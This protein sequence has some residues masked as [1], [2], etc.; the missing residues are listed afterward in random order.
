MN[1]NR[2]KLIKT[3]CVMICLTFAIFTNCS[4]NK[5]NEK[6]QLDHSNSQSQKDKPKWKNSVEKICIVFGYGYN[7]QEFVKSQVAS[8]QENYGISDGTENSG[9]IIPLV[10]PDDFKVGNTG[11][12]S[13]LVSLLEDVKVAGVITIGAPEYTNNALATLRENMKEGS[14]YP[15]YTLFP[16]DDILGIEATSDF[17]LDKAVE[18]SANENNIDEMKEENDQVAVEGIE[19]IINNAID[20][21]LLYEDP[22]KSNSELQSHVNAIVGGSYKIKRYVDPETGL[23]SINHFIIED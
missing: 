8:F 7:S 12:I 18:Q 13:K 23:S 2:I 10:Y 20:Y 6:N 14:E 16:Q 4:K 11:R 15:I 9:L 5:Q 17:V 1:K 3:F 21:I 19:T 22:L